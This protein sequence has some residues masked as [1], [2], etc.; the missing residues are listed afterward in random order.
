MTDPQRPRVP[1]FPLVSVP[2]LNKNRPREHCLSLK[3]IRGA[4][5][6]PEEE[7]GTTSSRALPRGRPPGAGSAFRNRSAA[8]GCHEAVWSERLPASP[9]HPGVRLSCKQGTEAFSAGFLYRGD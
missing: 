9:L 3:D 1:G 4:L 5:H 6:N 8:R 7:R 2:S